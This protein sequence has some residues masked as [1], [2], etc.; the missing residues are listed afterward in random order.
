MSSVPLPSGYGRPGYRPGVATASG[1]WRRQQGY[2]GTATMSGSS[3]AGSPDEGGYA[4]EQRRLTRRGRYDR[5]ISRA[6]RIRPARARAGDY[7]QYAES[8]QGGYAPPSAATRDVNVNTTT[9]NRVPRLRSAGGRLRRY[10]KAYGPPGL[11]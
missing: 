3:R 4:A 2:G 7:T 8:P 11:R 5:V 1:P 10:G 6:P 9:A